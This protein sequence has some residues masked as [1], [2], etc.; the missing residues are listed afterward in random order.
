MK[1][2]KKTLFAA[3]AVSAKSKVIKALLEVVP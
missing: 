1:N 2:D 3:A